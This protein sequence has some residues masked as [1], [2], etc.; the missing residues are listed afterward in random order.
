V[1]IGFHAIGPEVDPDHR[2]P[3]PDP[4]IQEQLQRYAELWLPGVDHR[5]AVST[6]C[7]Y[8]QTPDHHFVI[9]RQ[10]PII[11][12]A[13]FSGHGFKF[14]PALGELVARLSLDGATT[15]PLFAF[16]PH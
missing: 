8:T 9:D 14:G 11:V 3:T 5:S 10:G 15:P 16:G 4:A 1:K 6:T 7:L 2:D 12:A 13:G